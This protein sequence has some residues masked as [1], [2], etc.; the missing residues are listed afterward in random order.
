MT[1]EF[2][3]KELGRLKYFLRIEVAHSKSKIFISQQKY[4]HNL[5][6]DTCKL[7]WKPT[8]TFIDHN[9]KLRIAEENTLVNKKIYQRLL[10]RLIYLSHMRPKI[11]NVASAIGMVEENTPIKKLY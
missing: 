5:L 11:A 9:H 4:I 6:R 10:E 3:I 2:Q 7:A 1:K 8:S